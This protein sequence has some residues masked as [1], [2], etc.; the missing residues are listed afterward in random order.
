[1]GGNNALN[2]NKMETSRL[3]KS[4]PCCLWSTE[5]FS[6]QHHQFLLALVDLLE[7]VYELG[8]LDVAVLGQEEGFSRLAEELYKLAI[9][10]WADVGQP[11]VRGVD[12]GADGGVQQL[13]EGCL[14]RAHELARVAAPGDPG[15]ARGGHGAAAQDVREYGGAVHAFDH[16][17][18]E[19]GKLVLAQRV[20]QSAGPQDVVDGRVRVLVVGQVEV[21]HGQRGQ[22]ERPQRVT[23]VLHVPRDSEQL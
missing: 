9:V 11:R 22:F 23:A 12:V 14:V 5:T 21:G 2:L 13:P 15:Q 18:D 17:R 19:G 6:H 10:A 16:E 7:V 8:K 4:P 20:A 1:M 3:Q